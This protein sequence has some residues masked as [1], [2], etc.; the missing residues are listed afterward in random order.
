M[1]SRLDFSSPVK[2][3]SLQ[4][5]LDCEQILVWNF[6]LLRRSP[7]KSKSGHQEVLDNIPKHSTNDHNSPSSLL[8]KLERNSSWTSFIMPIP[9]FLSHMGG[10]SMTTFN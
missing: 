3:S 1:A 10:L 8:D 6:L 9:S 4:T 7:L 5:L 2:A